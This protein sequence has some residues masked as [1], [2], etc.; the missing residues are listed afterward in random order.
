MEI[1]NPSPIHKG[2]RL[3]LVDELKG[4]AMVLVLLYHIGGVLGWENW[5][6]GEIFYNFVQRFRY[7]LLHFS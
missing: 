1:L 7:Y 4:F 3:E 6:H 2:L 5:L